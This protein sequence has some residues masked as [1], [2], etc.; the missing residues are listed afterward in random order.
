V[1]DK[2]T[3]CDDDYDEALK[4]CIEEIIQEIHRVREL[5]NYTVGDVYELI[6]DQSVESRYKEYLESLRT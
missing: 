2:E 3:G 1:I 4:F 5:N 6:F